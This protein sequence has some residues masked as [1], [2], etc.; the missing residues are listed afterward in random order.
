MNLCFK[1]SLQTNLAGAKRLYMPFKKQGGGHIKQI[2]IFNDCGIRTQV[3]ALNSQLWTLIFDP[4]LN[5]VLSHANSLNISLQHISV[6]QVNGSEK[7]IPIIILKRNNVKEKKHNNDQYF[8]ALLILMNIETYYTNFFV[9]W[10]WRSIC[11]SQIYW[12]NSSVISK[13][14]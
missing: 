2:Q 14:H 13:I 10:W 8:W 6:S 3:R 12:N 11:I 7:S 1:F 9:V 5:T 4:I